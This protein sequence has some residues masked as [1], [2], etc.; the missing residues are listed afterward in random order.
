[1]KIASLLAQFFY[2]TKQLDIPGIGSFHLEGDPFFGDEKKPDHIQGVTFKNDRSVRES[3]QL[4]DYISQH[5]GKIRA[6]ASADLESFW[7]LAI[8]FLQIGKPFTIDGIGSLI[9]LQSGDYSFTPGLPIHDKIDPEK[10]AG[11]HIHESEIDYKSI[12][13]IKKIGQGNWKR[14]LAIVLFIT[15]LGAAIWGGYIVS[16]S[17][18]KENN[19]KEANKP[20]PEVAGPDNLDAPSIPTRTDTLQTANTAG[21]AD[22]ISY[23]FVVETAEKKR[24]LARY[25]FLSHNGIAVKMETIDSLSFDLYFL[26]KSIPADTLR[27]RDSLERFYTPVGKKAVV[28]P[29][30]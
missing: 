15:G 11:E 2:S 18:N 29:Q 5:T 25:E 12:L 16:R 24:A 14:P 10:Q 21:S 6:L 20:V 30:G 23:K 27:I 9:K 26:L 4:V 22:S 1:M 17:G 28:R 3:A 7:E 19:S 8:Q 13:Y